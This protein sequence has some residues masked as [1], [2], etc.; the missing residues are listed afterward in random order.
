MSNSINTDLLERTAETLDLADHH[1]EYW[2]GTLWEDKFDVAKAQVIRHM[3]TS[4]EDLY[5]HSL[6]ALEQLIKASS[7]E[8]FEREF[9]P[10][11][12]Y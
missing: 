3:D 12:Q 6:P 9:Q 1:A 10:N 5:Y 2:V 4:L 7:I 8:M 11:E